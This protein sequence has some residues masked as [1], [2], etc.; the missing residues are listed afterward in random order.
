MICQLNH[1]LCLL[2]KINGFGTKE[3]DQN[4]QD[5]SLQSPPRSCRMVEDHLV[6]QIIGSTTDGVRTRM[7]FKGNHKTMISQLE[8]KLINEAII[9]DSWIED[10]KDELSQFERNKVWNLVPN[11]QGKTIIRTRWIFRNKLDEDGKVVRNKTRLVA[12]CYNQQEGIDNDE[13]FAPVARLEAI[14]ILLAYA[15]HK[16]IKLFQ[17][18]VKSAFLNVFLNEEV[19]VIQPH[20]FINEEKPNH[21]FKLTKAFYGL[22]QALKAWYDRLSKFLIEK[23]FSRGK[24]DA[25]LFRKTHNSDLLI[26]EV[27]VDDIIFGA[28]KEKMCEEF[29]NLVRSEFEMSMMGELSFFPWFA[30]QTTSKWNFHKSRKVC[31]R[32]S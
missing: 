8:P 24:I 18:D 16:S 3:D 27:Y 21:V 25:T 7:S 17:M 23:G 29:S 30:N 26:V 1:V 4:V 5:L 12:Q 14:R 6:D 13:T 15:A 28:T 9:D 20:G 32:H 10:M 19:Y 2:K 31:Q 22:K 11:N